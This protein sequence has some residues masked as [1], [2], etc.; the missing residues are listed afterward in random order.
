MQGL[1]NNG[2]TTSVLLGTIKDRGGT[3]LLKMWDTEVPGGH[4]LFQRHSHI[5]FEITVV[6]AGSGT[7]S[8]KEHAFP[9]QAGDIFIFASNEYHCITDV[10][11]GG[12]HLTN[13]HIE[14]RFLWSKQEDSFFET[15][16]EFG[17]F[18]SASF[19]NRIPAETS[20]I[21]RQYISNIIAEL[22][23]AAPESR[24]AIRSLLNLL[25]ITLIRQHH[26]ENPTTAANK[27]QGQNLQRILTYIDAHFT[28]KVTLNELAAEAGMSPNYFSA[29]FKKI[30]G[31]TLWDYINSKR[32]DAAARMIRDPLN[33]KN[34][35]QIAN[36][37][38]FNNTTHFNKIF[39][40]STGMTPSEYKKNNSY[41][42]H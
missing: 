36:E 17:L 34:M 8:T 39:K 40:R 22:Q 29:F 26:S 13:L 19:P 21:P 9:M 37:S 11:T 1:L 16:L 31:I 41:M 32:V 10:G 33:D 23:T 42:I 15:E 20:E 38:G 3:T 6:N 30:S 2:A 4:H 18:H 12:L 28:E 35:L 27:P 14:P 7:Y 5:N 24:L 25:L